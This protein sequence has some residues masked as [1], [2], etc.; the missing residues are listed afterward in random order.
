MAPGC[1]ALWTARARVSG[2]LIVD[3]GHAFETAS[4]LTR[5]ADIARSF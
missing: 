1:K 3:S 4:G 2:R 5:S